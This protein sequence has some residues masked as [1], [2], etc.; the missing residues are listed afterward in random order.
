[1]EELFLKLVSTNFNNKN[2]F[3]GESVTCRILYGRVRKLPTVQ[4]LWA[5]SFFVY[6][7]LNGWIRLYDEGLF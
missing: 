7:K 3:F 6:T 2:R 1:M 5:T 4:Y